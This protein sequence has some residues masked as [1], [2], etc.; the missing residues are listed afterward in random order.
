MHDDTR[1][2]DVLHIEIIAPEHAP[3]WARDRASLLNAMEV[4]ESRK[5]A[6]VSREVRV[7]LPAKLTPEQNRDLAGGFVQAQ[8]VAC[9]MVADIAPPRPPA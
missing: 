6:Q 2:D 4:I 7:A 3:D 8:L 5:D 1:K 9:G